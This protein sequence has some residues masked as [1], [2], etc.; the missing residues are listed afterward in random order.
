MKPRCR[1]IRAETLGHLF[2]QADSALPA[3][4]TPARQALTEEVA[5]L[6]VDAAL[7]CAAMRKEASH[8]R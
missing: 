6:L 1:S 5:R 4:P 7:R 2:R 3:L 8:E